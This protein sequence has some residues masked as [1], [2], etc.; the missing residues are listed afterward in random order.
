MVERCR[1]EMR[2]ERVSKNLKRLLFLVFQEK[3]S[4]PHLREMQVA[5]RQGLRI[6]VRRRGGERKHSSGVGMGRGVRILGDGE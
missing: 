6:R 4:G 3:L 1:Q 5:K 2:M